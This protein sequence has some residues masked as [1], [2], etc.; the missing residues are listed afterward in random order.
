M[1]ARLTFEQMFSVFRDFPQQIGR[2]SHIVD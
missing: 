1:V 2:R